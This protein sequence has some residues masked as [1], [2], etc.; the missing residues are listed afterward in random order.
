MIDIW[1]NSNLS[2]W[3]KRTKYEIV[4]TELVSVAT[5]SYSHSYLYLSSDNFALWFITDKL[6]VPNRNIDYGILTV[7]MDH[8]STY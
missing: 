8:F 6:S 1:M 2:Q 3:W 4:A 7:S 5:I